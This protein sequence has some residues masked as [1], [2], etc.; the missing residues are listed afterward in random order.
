MRHRAGGENFWRAVVS[1]GE[2]HTAASAISVSVTSAI[3][4]IYNNR[5]E[6]AVPCNSNITRSA[7]VNSSTHVPGAAPAARCPTPRGSLVQ[8][9]AMPMARER[10]T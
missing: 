7:Y 3:T 5:S 9:K 1:G 6:V 2:Q 4:D 10:D 8:R